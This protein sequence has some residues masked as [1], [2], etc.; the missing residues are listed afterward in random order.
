[1]RSVDYRVC[2]LRI[3][4]YFGSM[5]K[6]SKIMNVGVASI[7][8]WSKRIDVAKWPSR[9]SKIVDA[10][11]AVI[12]IVLDREPY[13][14]ARQLQHRIKTEFCLDVSRQLVSLTVRSK[15]GYSWKRTRKRGPRGVGWTD[16]K[17]AEFKLQFRLAYQQGRLSSWDESS[18]D[19]RC[20]PIYGYAPKG[21]QSIVNVPRLFCS[22]KHHSLLLGIHMNGTRHHQVLT[23]TVNSAIFANFVLQAPYPRGTVVLLDNHSMHK[24]AVVK[25]AADA[26]GYTLLN[27]PPYSPEFNP[28]ELVFGVTKNVFYKTRYADVGRTDTPQVISQC[29]SSAATPATVSACCKHVFGLVGGS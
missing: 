12:K 8:R 2:C 17:V 9:G 16:D 15:L 3:Y 1:M 13:T 24:T 23:G 10:V 27:T 28:I 25:A 6:A 19:M 11:E 29:L 26:K 7:S 18:F 21:K 5:R 20:R 4:N 14:T 22:Q